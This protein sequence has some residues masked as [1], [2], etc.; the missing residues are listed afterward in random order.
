MKLPVAQ[1]MHGAVVKLHAV[2]APQREGLGNNLTCGIFLNVNQIEMD[3]KVWG[4]ELVF[5][6]KGENVL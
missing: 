1:S 6:L 2:E 3:C 4:L 5:N